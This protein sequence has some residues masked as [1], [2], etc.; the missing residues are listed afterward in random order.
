MEA[1]SQPFNL[2]PFTCMKHASDM[3]ELRAP[4]LWDMLV[5]GQ[6]N[7][8]IRYIIY[9]MEATSQPFKG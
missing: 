7:L 1:T 9:N 4:N 3:S 5:M 8:C 2:P 6:T